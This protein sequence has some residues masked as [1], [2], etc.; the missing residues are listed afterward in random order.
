MKSQKAGILSRAADS[1]LWIKAETKPF[2]FTLLLFFKGV[3][4]Y[5]MVGL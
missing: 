5:H 3:H 4:S 2:W 1:K